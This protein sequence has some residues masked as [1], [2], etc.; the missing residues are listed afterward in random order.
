MHSSKLAQPTEQRVQQSRRRQLNGQQPEAQQ[1]EGQQQGWQGG[2]QPQERQQEQQQGQYSSH[3]E[4]QSTGRYTRQVSSS[5]RAHTHQPPPYQPAQQLP[6]QV[7]EEWAPPPLS[8]PAAAPVS[9]PH[10]PLRLALQ[11]GQ[12]AAGQAG[13]SRREA[14]QEAAQGRAGGKARQT[15]VLSPPLL[16]PQAAQQRPVHSPPLGGWEQQEQGREEQAEQGRLGGPHRL[17]PG[18]QSGAALHDQS[19]VKDRGVGNLR[20]RMPRPAPDSDDDK[21]ASSASS[22]QPPAR[23]DPVQPGLAHE[24]L[25]QPSSLRR[26]PSR[27]LMQANGGAD[28]I[29]GEDAVKHDSSLKP[30]VRRIPRPEPGSSGDELPFQTKQPGQ[31]RPVS[32]QT[33]GDVSSRVSKPAG[34]CRNDQQ[35]VLAETKSAAAVEKRVALAR[36]KAAAM[37]SDDDV[38]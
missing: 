35:A 27:P 16:P 23:N 30:T 24:P 2:W 38:L 7:E 17:A 32:L 3:Y 29:A 9:A 10:P 1:P 22:L 8:S 36:L 31:S 37:D 26:P 20:R 12:Q 21:E 14:G 33:N 19:H 15:E 13:D 6:A 4:E 25:V 11:Q 5:R 18:A 28:R 34:S